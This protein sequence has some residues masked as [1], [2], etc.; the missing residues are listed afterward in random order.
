MPITS[1]RDI[2]YLSKDFDSIKSD[3]IDYVKRH[4]PS[5]WRDFNDASGGMAL[6]ELIA[7]VGDILSFN[8]DRQ[9]NEAYINRA[10][11]LKNIIS[12]AENFGYKPNNTT[13]A[14]VNL[15]VSADFANTT[16]AESL[17][18]MK[19]GATVLTNYEPVVAFETLSDVDFSNPA[20]RIIQTRGATTTVSVSSVSAVAG[21]SKIFRYSAG[22]PVKFLK[23]TLPD[24]NINEVMSVSAADGSEYYE[25]D[26]LA[27]DTVFVG[28]VNTSNTSGDA[29]YIMR[30]KR[31]PKRFVVE[32]D[33]S[34][35]TSIRFGPG[36]L[37][38]ADADI[39]P[40]PNDFV[41]P[42]TLRGSPSGFAPASID[43]TNFLKTKSLG[44]APQNT[45]IT[46][47]YRAGGGVAT[48]VGV[49][50]LTRIINK[51][52]IFATP[53]MNSLSATVVTN[54][55]NSLACTN[56]EQA[57]GGEQAETVA[58]I[59]ENAVFNMGSQLRCVTLQDYQA[60]VMSM[61]A[62]F[63]SVFRN[64]VR[65]DPNNS[66]GVEMFM[67]TRNNQKQLTLPSDVIKNNIET[68]IKNFK[69]FS[70]TIKLTSGRII[71]IGVDFTM[72]PSAGVNGQVALMECI[73]VLQRLF[74][75]GRT[76]FNDSIVIP[77]IQARLQ[78]LRTVRSVPNLK[79]I[80]RTT[81][82]G[83]RTYSGTELNINANTS[84]GILQFPQDS[85]WEL[86][87]PN[88]D[89]IGRSADQSTAAAGTAGGG[90][91]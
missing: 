60:R 15:A 17:F 64:F 45:E 7:Y 18:T 27:R 50:S 54:V 16:S 82:V 53:E 26:N 55:T 61:P 91:Y 49:G 52:L 11:E 39:I 78:S 85:V 38:E 24:S 76:N 36:V 21:I 51:D 58:S 79:I 3:L 23:L 81:T 66:M 40:N 37:M 57:S 6:L 88:F 46:V 59:R 32:R 14:V 90:G 9:V 86:K 20:N 5:D 10:V 13:P 67:I 69:S 84:S 19:K 31:V 30:L 80:N 63:G 47:T 2:N 4:F 41:L 8:I 29:G 75:T 22:D 87:Y 73:M 12:L 42:P 68:Y 28:D 1:N 72:V 44:V 77:D 74:D 56:G 83:T 43:S 48:N 35:L 25:V 34:G 33:P 71:N 65:K 70:D 89:I 62:S